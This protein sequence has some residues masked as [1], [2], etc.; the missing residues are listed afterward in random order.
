MK[1]IT[2][3][4]QLLFS[5]RLAAGIVILLS[6]IGFT[7][8]PVTAAET[9]PTLAF[10]TY[11]GGD[12][13]DFGQDIAVD[14]DGNIYV[15]GTTLSADFPTT[16]S[17]ESADYTLFVSKF[18][19]TGTTLLYSTVIGT[20]FAEAIA[21]DDDGYAYV[22]GDGTHLPTV[23]A[24]QST[25]GGG[26]EDVF[27]AKINPSGT[28]LVYATYL[29]GS[30]EDSAIGVALDSV[31]NVFVLGITNSTNFPTLNAYQTLKSGE[32]DSFLARLNPSGSALIYST[33]LGGSNDDVGLDIAADT[34]GNVYIAG[35]TTSHN[36]PTLNAYQLGIEGDCPPPTICQDA[37][38]AKFNT[39]GMPV[40]STYLGGSGYSE[41]AISITI[42]NQYSAYV[43]GY[44]NSTD[45]PIRNAYQAIL[46][47][48]TSGFVTKFTPNGLQLAYSTYL[49]GTT[50]TS[51]G[52]GI[53]VDDA[54][55]AAVVGMTIATDF[56]VVKP[57][58]AEISGTGNTNEPFISVLSP[59]GRSLEFSTYFGGSGT[60]DYPDR[61]PRVVFDR[62][63]NLLIVGT[64]NSADFP[65]LNPFQDQP[66]GSPLINDYDAFVAKIAFLPIS[67]P[68][69][70]A[71]RNY[72]TTHTPT[73]TWKPVT[74][75]LGY[76][77][78]VDESQSFAE[79]YD[80]EGDA[81]ASAD[82]ITTT[83]LDDGFYYWRILAQ[84]PDGTWG[85][86]SPVGSF[87]I[88][89]D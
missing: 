23:N 42:D 37:F 81:L 41:V 59:N 38:V 87:T 83:H 46:P 39:S 35:R 6:I 16:S 49:S 43:T 1:L 11:L 84:K 63:G 4:L 51:F 64:T 72:F 47:S 57:I 77:I 21:V 60:E 14:K 30:G 31:G 85:N 76:R 36:F 48:A 26:N 55:R 29:G 73:L 53:A 52:T 40:F 70:A 27:I 5:P 12:N 8:A 67:L 65:T 33:Y 45:F 32:R 75:A 10:S 9:D 79:P 78:Q 66:G 44:T 56:P 86:I 18:D 7:V 19:P 89:V 3:S 58:Q 20:G 50:N 25:Y 28:A 2:L 34:D 13:T 54:G 68:T 62:N 88:D 17:L 82:S 80:F 22:V 74:W 69:E 24:I 15:A 61:I 71:E